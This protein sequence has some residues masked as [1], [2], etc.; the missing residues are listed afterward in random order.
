MLVASKMAMSWADRLEAVRSYVFNS[1]G[2]VVTESKQG[3]YT[4]E[5]A[6]NLTRSADSMQQEGALL[7]IAAVLLK[8]TEGLQQKT[9]KDVDWQAVWTYA[10]GPGLE[11][12]SSL[13]LALDDT[14][15]GVIAACAKALHA[16]LSCS[17]NETLFGIQESL[18]PGNKTS[19]TAPVFRRKT[20]LEEGFIGGGRWKYHVRS[21]DLYPE[22]QIAQH[23]SGT[24]EDRD[25]V[26]DEAAVLSKDVA[27]G[28]LRMD[29]LTRI[30]N[31]F[32]KE[33][34][35]TADE[36]LLYVVIAL[37]R[38]SP[39]A[40]KAVMQCPRLLDSVI[41]RFLLPDDDLN[42]GLRSAHTKSI[43]LLKILSQASAANCIRF[44][45][46]GAL[47]VAQ[48]ELYKQGFPLP[49]DPRLGEESFKGV[50]AT[51]VECL[52]LWRVCIN[53]QIGIALFPDI[54]PA[55]C[56][57]LA[58]LSCKEITSTTSEDMLFLAQ[59]S[60]SL[61]ERLAWTL[62]VLH[63]QG[64]VHENWTWSVAL[65]LVETAS[66]WL[67]KDRIAAVL[68][69]L[70]NPS[71][72][73]IYYKLVATVAS[74]FHFLSTVCEMFGS[75]EQTN[76]TKHPV[77]HKIA[78]ALASN[79]LLKFNTG[80]TNS[81]LEVMVLMWG[82]VD[83]VTAM[84][85]TSCIHGLVRLLNVTDHLYVKTDE[86]EI[87]SRGLVES[88]DGELRAL[89]T[90]LGNEVIQAKDIKPAGHEGV[91]IVSGPAPGLG[92]GWGQVGGGKWSKHGLL[93]N[94][95]ARL[96]SELLEILPFRNES[97]KT[98][99]LMWR[100]SCC[101]CAA[102]VFG[103]GD[104][105]MVH[106]LFSNVLLLS[107]TV[108]L[109]LQ[110]VD[111]NQNGS[112][113]VYEEI[114]HV[115]LEHFKKVWICPKPGKSLHS[116]NRSKKLKTS[117]IATKLSNLS[118]ESAKLAEEK[119]GMD[120]L[121]N[122]MVAEWANQRL[123]LPLHSIFSPMAT[124]V[125]AGN[126]PECTMLD[127]GTFV[128]TQDEMEDSMECGVAWLL[129]LEVL[130][131]SL[132]NQNENLFAAIPIVRKVHSLSSM[133]LLG[134]DVYLRK[135]LKACIASLQRL[136]GR[137][138]VSKSTPLDFEGEIDE[139]YRSFVDALAKKFSASKD[140]AFGSQVAIYL[141]QDVGSSIRLQ[142]WRSLA[143]SKS[144]HL[145][146]PLEDCPGDPSGYLLPPEKNVA[147]IEAFV[148]AWTSGE[149]EKAVDGKTSVATALALHHIAA[150]LF[151]E[152][153]ATNEGLKKK[154][155]K[156]LVDRPQQH[157]ELLRRLLECSLTYPA[158]PVSSVE[159]ERRLSFMQSMCEGDELRRVL[160][161]QTT[162]S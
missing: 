9:D 48:C 101:L 35:R 160:S 6:V 97:N 25:S 122:E 78:L 63:T 36:N 81:M 155:V 82:K 70:T 128:I 141:R 31:I 95:V 42:D 65:P 29:I 64:S 59:E 138:L 105:E 149:L 125:N 28:L 51:V 33:Q 2:N 83:E 46:T 56:Y 76:G 152:S 102:S 114:S 24:E 22:T 111:E 26:G 49:S 118:E 146:P 136:Y 96:V 5:D 84:A 93:M 127:D 60:Y 103:P 119:S 110:G 67:A 137:L 32:E 15:L 117:L 134:G 53:H 77:V 99:E 11:L 58:P 85:V 17:A 7:L 139:N 75:E 19:F 8:A 18:W 43:Q 161:F 116:G 133:F 44:A 50:C 104:A 89:L 80:N 154:L 52:R 159:I 69:T 90:F 34:V 145:L 10:M 37:S 143:A 151:G 94:G 112:N 87:L 16:L 41:Q 39:A 135:S 54:Y 62:P 131:Q 40:A 120:W 3:C 12:A 47:Q 72:H 73:S 79:N 66:G 144:L 86:N 129:G 45:E 153:S 108:T 27:A 92:L 4:L 98:A 142:T 21:S 150:F 107:E 158:K 13:R 61:L 91:D 130:S 14:N 140:A 162:P 55:L 1:D 38:H 147:M 20:D 113:V 71:K 100:I 57:W 123:P 109:V 148:S 126:G 132:S 115:L 30:Q 88:A 156:T 74:V 124:N 23:F 68:A 106:K 121:S 157:Q